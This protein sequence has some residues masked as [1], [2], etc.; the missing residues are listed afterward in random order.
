MNNYEVTKCPSCSEVIVTSEVGTIKVT[1]ATNLQEVVERLEAGEPMVDVG[2]DYCSY[3]LFPIASHISKEEY[4]EHE[5][6]LK[7]LPYH[8]PRPQSGLNT[9]V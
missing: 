1:G 2:K 9:Y 6:H 3:C 5:K 7:W 4:E 8:E